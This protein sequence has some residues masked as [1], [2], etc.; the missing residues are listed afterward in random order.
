V[1]A[2]V[3]APRYPRLSIAAPPKYRIGATTFPSLQGEGARPCRGLDSK[4]PSGEI[5]PAARGHQIL[6]AARGKRYIVE[7]T[8]YG[9][10]ILL[11]NAR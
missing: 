4:W 1:P 10:A 2:P 3:T 8:K 9:Y 5:L 6:R 7:T 11:R